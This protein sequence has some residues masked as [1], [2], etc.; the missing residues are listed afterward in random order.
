MFGALAPSLESLDLFVS[1]VDLRSVSK[2]AA[3]HH[4]SQPS[5]SARVTELEI[6]LK[7]RLLDR[8]SH[9]SYVTELGRGIYELAKETLHSAERFMSKA[10]ELS[11]YGSRRLRIYAS[12]SIAE[13]LLPGWLTELKRGDQ[14]LSPEL[15]VVNSSR[16]IERVKADGDL[17]FIESEEN[18]QDLV[19]TTVAND[20]LW[21]VVS[22]K[23][24]WAQYKRPIGCE[25][26]A[27]SPLVLRESGSGTRSVF[28]N[29]MAKA[30]FSSLN[31]E[32][33]IGSTSAIK[34][35]LKFGETVSVLSGLTVASEV[36]QAE[37]V[38]VDVDQLDLHRLLHAVWSKSK[39]VS[40][41]EQ[42]LVN[43]CLQ[44]KRSK[45]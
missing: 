27:T 11:D 37:L 34:S 43:V 1:I 42:E 9:G 25:M 10:E 3:V 18:D 20:E 22:P 35:I 21:V 28:E 36:N 45:K 33:E 2:A 23:H 17:G 16:V 8:T 4:I 14:T 24:P 39:D 30:G 12:F 38:K 13:Y 40:Y 6:L 44:L 32:A 31:I 41:S 29:R 7:V 19:R 5:A 15:M 26:L